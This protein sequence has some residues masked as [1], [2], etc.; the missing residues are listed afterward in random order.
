ML[1]R[2]ATKPATVRQRF[3]MKMAANI[4]AGR[5]AFQRVVLDFEMMRVRAMKWLAPLL[6]TFAASSA[7]AQDHGRVGLVIGYPAAAGVILHVSDRVAV[8]PDVSFS[9]TSQDI[10]VVSSI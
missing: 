10:A 4:S 2:N 3:T 5:P 6:A 8:R 9:Q 7:A 1:D